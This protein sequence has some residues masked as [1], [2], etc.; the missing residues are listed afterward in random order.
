[1]NVSPFNLVQFC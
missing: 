1:M